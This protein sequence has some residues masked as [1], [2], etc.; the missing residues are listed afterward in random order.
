MKKRIFNIAGTIICILLLLSSIFL[1]AIIESGEDAHTAK[2]ECGLFAALMAFGVYRGL[3]HLLY[4]PK[5][6]MMP[7][8]EGIKYNVIPVAQKKVV[9]DFFNPLK[10]EFGTAF[11]IFLLIS[12]FPGLLYNNTG[13][14]GLFCLIL[15]VTI[16]LKAWVLYKYLQLNKV[17]N[18]F[19]LASLAR[20]GSPI[21]L[22]YDVDKK[23]IED[24]HAILL[25]IIDPVSQNV[26]MLGSYKDFLNDS[27][28]VSVPQKH[29]LAA[30]LYE[31]QVFDN[32]HY[33]FFTETAGNL[34][35]DAIE[36]LIAIGA[37]EYAEVLRKAA[38][39]F[40]GL[41]H[42]MHDTEERAALIEKLGLDFEDDDKA[43]YELYGSA[44]D[45][46]EENGSYEVLY[47]KQ[48]AYIKAH[49]D[50]FVF[51]NPLKQV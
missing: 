3:R 25:E 51:S 33:T 46:E 48:M 38:S 42:P 20:L 11:T 39:R 17:L 30:H 50:D 29:I 22:T 21:P 19:G 40:D 15:V 23:M 26:N 32:G 34:Y 10:M 27:A 8:I 7:T 31:N 1:F 41:A 24:P 35:L 6:V 36:G 16:S 14:T 45:S 37:G 49:A 28:K 43:L 47:D 12:F 44:E 13:I 18:E 5:Q 2:V 9:L 4:R